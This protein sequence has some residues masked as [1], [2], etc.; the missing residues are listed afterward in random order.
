[1]NTHKAN[2]SECQDRQTCLATAPRPP[3][4][5]SFCLSSAS[6]FP[7]RKLTD[8]LPWWFSFCWAFSNVMS[9]NRGTFWPPFSLLV[10]FKEFDFRFLSWNIYDIFSFIFDQSWQDYLDSITLVTSASYEALSRKVF[11]V[12]IGIPKHQLAVI[13]Q[14]FNISVRFF[15]KKLFPRRL[16]IFTAV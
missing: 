9:S 4:F 8:R 3:S 15:L 14:E 11:C 10:I 12:V 1:M 5:E 2:S 7:K 6:W 16:L 13:E